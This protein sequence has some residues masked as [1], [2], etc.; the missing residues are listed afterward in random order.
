MSDEQAQQQFSIARIYVKDLSYEAPNAPQSFAVEW[1]PDLNLEMNS[2]SRLVDQNLWEVVLQLTVTVKNAGQ[3]AFIVEVQQA[4]L[5]VVQG[6]ENEQLRHL[7]GAFC[8]NILFPYA[9]ETVSDLV[10]R[11]SFPQ[12]LLAPVNFDALFM[13]AM[14]REAQP[15]QVQ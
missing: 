7:L 10:T 13:E 15:P 9:R 8:P 5:F 11:G 6:I 14:Q 1:K 12:L 2:Q 4:G 3:T